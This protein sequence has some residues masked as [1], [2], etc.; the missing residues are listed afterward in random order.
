MQSVQKMFDFSLHVLRPE[1]GSEMTKNILHDLVL[2]VP[3]VF[4]GSNV[5]IP[6]IF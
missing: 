5:C 1:L 2:P 6:G 3:E 4:S